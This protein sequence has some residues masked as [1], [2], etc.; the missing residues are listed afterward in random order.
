MN[1]TSDLIDKNGEVLKGQLSIE[2]NSYKLLAGSFIEGKQTKSLFANEYYPL[3]KKIK[4][5]VYLRW[6][7]MK[8]S[9]FL[10]AMLS[11]RLFQQQLQL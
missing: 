10:S 7:N 11:F 4:L 1:L 2:A 5:T 3:R 6:R 8:I 9:M